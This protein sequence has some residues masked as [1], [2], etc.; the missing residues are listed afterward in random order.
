MD[1]F[2]EQI[3]P[4]KKTG[5]SY[6]CILGLW[7][8]ALL[9]CFVL[10]LLFKYIG[11]IIILLY[12]G[13]IY[14]TFKLSSMLNIEYEYII[15]NGSMDIDRIINKSNRKRVLSFE[16]SGVTRLEKYNPNALNNIN[17]KDIVFAC[18]KN[19]QNAYFMVAEK[20]GKKPNYLIFSPN[21]KIKSAVVK[22]VPKFISLNA[23]K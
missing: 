13:V 19:D 3:I 1:T 2:F 10:L 8:A 23:F 7:F 17:P 4:I 18:D 12:A 11:S 20:E 5:K 21:E 16:L 15:T 9:L 6:A 14:G 22:Y